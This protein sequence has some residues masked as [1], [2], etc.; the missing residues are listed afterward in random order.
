[1]ND[2]FK[3]MATRWG[4]T[5]RFC[6]GMILVGWGLGTMGFWGVM[7]TL[8]GAV[9]MFTGATDLCLL[10]PFWNL[11][12]TGVMLRKHFGITERKLDLES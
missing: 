1:M 7:A 6:I 8:I 2:F 12:I 4:R 9:A 11:P 5:T 3:F 10:A